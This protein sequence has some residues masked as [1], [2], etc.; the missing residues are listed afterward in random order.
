MMGTEDASR[1]V[2]PTLGWLAGFARPALTGAATW[3]AL[4][5]YS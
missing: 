3:I 2:P 5:S 4:T 1:R